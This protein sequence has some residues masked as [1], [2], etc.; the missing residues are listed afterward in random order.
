MMILAT[1]P[2]LARQLYDS[3]EDERVV[4]RFVEEVL[5][6]EPPSHGLYRTTMKEV[7]L[8]GTRL[9]AGA[10]VCILFA[11]AND[12]DTQF[13][14]P[15]SL[16]ITRPNITKHITFGAGIHLCIGAALARMEIKVAAQEIIRRLDNI[17][18]AIPMEELTYLPSLATQTLERLPL[19]FTRRA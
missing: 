10:Q 7:E 17:R 15:R 5:R 4:M 14:C 9:P 19:T 12:D 1:Q 18:L 6:L 3:R 8:G 16:D 13:T 11:S 2:Q